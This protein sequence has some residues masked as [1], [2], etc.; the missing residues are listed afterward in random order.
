MSLLRL[1]RLDR[2]QDEALTTP[3]PSQM[4]TGVPLAV[5]DLRAGTELPSRAAA[6]TA[7][8]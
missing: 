2:R 3:G 5:A 8:S 4:A 6:L 7:G 1:L